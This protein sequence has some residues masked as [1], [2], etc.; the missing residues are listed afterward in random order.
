[1]VPKLSH[2]DYTVAWICPL[3][4]EQ[5]AALHM[6]DEEHEILPQPPQDHNTYILGCINGHNVVIAGLTA[7]GNVSAATVATQ[8]RNTF[9]SLRFALLVGIG[10]GVPTKTANGS[11]RLGDLV[12]SKPQGE[13]SG[14]VQYDRGKA[15]HDG[16]FVRIG[17]LAP[18]PKLLLSVAQTLEIRR[19]LARTDPL[20]EALQRIDVS[21][22]RLRKYRYPGRKEDRLYRPSYK[23]ENPSLDCAKCGCSL[24]QLI[25]RQ[26]SDDEDEDYSEE[27]D[28]DE[29]RIHRGNIAS[30]EA[31]M[32]DG[33]LRDKYAAEHNILCFE[34][35]AAGVL[36]DFPCLV[37]RGI[38]DYS[39]S[40][41]T[42]RWQGYAAAVAASYARQLFFYLPKHAVAQEPKMAASKASGHS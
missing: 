2:G 5:I 22:P 20:Q 13:H 29:I 18:P 36:D 16:V 37:I 14:V 8:M 15:E 27:E 9:T 17:S 3:Q 40:H 38:S 42:S 32:K 4:I 31:V 30:G 33:L 7:A 41:K 25:Q 26:H 34:M 35:E 28:E 10:G 39:D 1:M 21:R 23:H 24:D 12:V 19:Q 6:L 11:I